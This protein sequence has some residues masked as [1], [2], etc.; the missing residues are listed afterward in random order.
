M[1]SN[2]PLITISSTVTTMPTCDTHLSTSD[3][4]K[5]QSE[6]LTQNK[7]H[8]PA[9]LS[10]PTLQIAYEFTFGYHTSSAKVINAIAR[11]R[12]LKTCGPQGTV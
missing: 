8:M 11:Q 5:M 1:H 12:R 3:T 2:M 4:S 7:I 6:R 10:S 9:A